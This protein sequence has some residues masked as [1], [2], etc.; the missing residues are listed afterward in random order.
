M[1]KTQ[2]EVREWLELP[3]STR[4]KLAS[5][6]NLTRSGNS[7]VMDHRV[8]SDGYVFHDLSKIS[9][10]LIRS[11]L[12]LTDSEFDFYKLFNLLLQSYEH[13]GQKGNEVK[14]AD[15][16]A[17]ETDREEQEVEPVR[18]GSVLPEVAR[19][20]KKR[21]GRPTNASSAR[22]GSTTGVRKSTKN[23]AS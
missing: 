7:E 3:L 9:V 20:P 17:D 12:N 8:I 2:L 11:Q 13:K 5:D 10:D 16:S 23:N 1:H 15:S 18:E 22:N 21:G 6:F 19:E 4:V 14:G